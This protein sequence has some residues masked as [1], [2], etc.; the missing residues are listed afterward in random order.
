MHSVELLADALTKY[1]GTLIFVSHDRFFISKTA[2]K[3]WEIDNNQIIEFK[4]SYQEWLEWKERMADQKPIQKSVT[5]SPVVVEKSTAPSSNNNNNNQT[6]ESA[7]K[8]APIDKELQKKMQKLQKQISQ[9]EDQMQQ[10]Q[11]EKL[12]LEAQM[13]DP[14]TYADPSLFSKVES[15]YKQVENENRQLNEQYEIAFEQ[16]AALEK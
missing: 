8:A 9:L 3:I 16:L 1:E 15:R 4:G 10:L 12:T 6:T 5:T 13:A 2:N 14:A 11:S 7:A